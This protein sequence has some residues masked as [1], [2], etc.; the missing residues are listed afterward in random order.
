[1]RPPAGW[2]FFM[3]PHR[4]EPEPEPLPDGA[5]ELDE[6]L[7]AF[8]TLGF[9]ALTALALAWNRASPADVRERYLKRGATHDDVARILA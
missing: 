7:E 2:G 3:P 8:V 4:P 6:R 9:D 1:M 5:E